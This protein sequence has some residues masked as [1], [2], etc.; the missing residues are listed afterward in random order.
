MLGLLAAVGG[1]LVSGFF[2][3]KQQKNQN[4]Q[5]K[6]MKQMEIEQE[7][8]LANYQRQNQLAD[9]KYKEDGVGNYRKF[10][11]G[12]NVN[13]QTVSGPESTSLSPQTTQDPQSKPKPLM[14][15]RKFMGWT[16][17]VTQQ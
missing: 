9:R 1:S 14:T 4:K 8:W 12:G 2:G 10:Y 5:D 11:G 15:T 6:E 13:G 16:I 3:S 17:P 7:K